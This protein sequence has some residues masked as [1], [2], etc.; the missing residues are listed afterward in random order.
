MIA[1]HARRDIIAI[2]VV[3]NARNASV[4]AARAFRALFA[5]HAQIRLLRFHVVVAMMRMTFV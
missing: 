2:V 1:R 4:G 5:H 3:V